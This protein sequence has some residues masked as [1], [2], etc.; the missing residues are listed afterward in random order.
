M[1]HQLLVIP[2][3]LNVLGACDGGPR[4]CMVQPASAPADAVPAI[5][6]PARTAPVDPYAPVEARTR[7]AGEFYFGHPVICGR[8]S[9]NGASCLDMQGSVVWCPI[10][11]MQPCVA[12]TPVGV[13]EITPTPT[14]AVE[15]KPASTVVE[16]E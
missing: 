8:G 1:R 11:L 13:V 4:I 5:A 7:V 2:L 15:I 6:A 3:L 16:K 14:T 12:R 10:S 9:T